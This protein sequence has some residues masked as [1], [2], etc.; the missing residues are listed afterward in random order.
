MPPASNAPSDEA[1]RELEQRALRNVRNLVD[2][3]EDEEA[4]RRVTLRRAIIGIVVVFALLAIAFL[5]MRGFHQKGAGRV[6]ESQPY[7]RA[8]P[9]I[10]PP[11]PDSAAKP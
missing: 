11:A 3:I 6:I 4:H 7:K 5:S 10:P 1:Q 9:A 2:R 8:V